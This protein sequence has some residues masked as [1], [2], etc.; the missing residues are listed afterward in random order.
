MRPE[1][2]SLSFGTITIDGTTFQHDVVILPSGEVI[3]RNKKP[4]KRKFGSGHRLAR[5]ELEEYFGSSP[6][7][8]L[9]VGTGHSGILC[10]SDGAVRFL[11]KRAIKA[12]FCPSPDAIRRFNEA[13]E[14]TAAIIHVTC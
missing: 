12:E 5:A 13:P 4:S 14:G 11:D 1:V 7:S 6:V 8:Q 9:I 2:D 10:F 3:R